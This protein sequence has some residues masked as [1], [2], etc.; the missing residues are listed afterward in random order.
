MDFAWERADRKAK[1]DLGAFGRS[2]P[3]VN[4]SLHFSA[5]SASYH[6][7]AIILK[8]FYYLSYNHSKPPNRTI[9]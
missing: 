9:P 7:L 4:G 2:H 1:I 3:S 6:V 8:D 5:P